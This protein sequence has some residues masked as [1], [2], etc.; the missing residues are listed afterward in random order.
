M[1]AGGGYKEHA[2]TKNTLPLSKYCQPNID[3]KDDFKFISATNSQMQSMA[4]QSFKGF[5]TPST[6]NKYSYTYIQRFY[7]AMKIFAK[8]HF[9]KSYPFYAIS[10]QL[11]ITLHSIKL[12]VARSL[13]A[14]R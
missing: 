3:I 10:I 14:K 6:T 2:G 9:T 7:G 11:L 4:G 12:L 5:Q 1:C 13:L 8:K